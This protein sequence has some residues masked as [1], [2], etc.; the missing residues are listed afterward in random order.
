MNL[1]E[2][3]KIKQLQLRYT[4]PLSGKLTDEQIYLMDMYK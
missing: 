1:T 3:F 4:L 2:Y